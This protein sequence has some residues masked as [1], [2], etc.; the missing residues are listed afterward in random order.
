MGAA[1][2]PPRGAP[3][4][5]LRLSSQYRRA[6]RWKE[7][8]SSSATRH[9]GQA[10]QQSSGRTRD[11]VPMNRHRDSICQAADCFKR[12]LQPAPGRPSA[13]PDLHAGLWHP[14]SARGR[15]AS[16]TSRWD[17]RSGARACRRDGGPLPWVRDHDGSRDEVVQCSASFIEEHRQ[18]L[19]ADPDHCDPQGPTGPDGLVRS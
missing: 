4:R 5:T 7:F 15:Q 1:T 8:R 11:G 14:A 13:A 17:G 9:E 19:A 16:A 6:C 18:D 2:R 3:A 12:H 10:C